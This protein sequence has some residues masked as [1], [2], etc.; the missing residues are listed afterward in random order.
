MCSNGVVTPFHSP[1]HRR[2]EAAARMDAAGADSRDSSDRSL[3]SQFNGIV[4]QRA[5]TSSGK[6]ETPVQPVGLDET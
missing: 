6:A 2:V 4:G 3:E 5:F 1:P